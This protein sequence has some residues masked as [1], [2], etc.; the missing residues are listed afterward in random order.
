VD[1][2]NDTSNCGACGSQCGENE[3]CVVGVCT[4][5]SGVRCLRP[6]GNTRCCP[7][8]GGV[9]C[10]TGKCCLPGGTCSGADQCLYE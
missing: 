5:Q 4:C 6:D 10:A 3:L 1:I 2:N 8:A 9:C 7:V